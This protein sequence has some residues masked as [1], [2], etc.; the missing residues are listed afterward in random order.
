M[1]ENQLGN[2][3]TFSKRITAADGTEI[4]EVL[5]VADVYAEYASLS[6][7]YHVGKNFYLEAFSGAVYLPSFEKAPFPEIFVE[8]NAAE[9]IAAMLKI[10]EEFPFIGLKFYCKKGASGIWGEL[11]TARLQNKGRELT[12]PFSTP[13]LS[14]NEIKILGPTDHIGVQIINYGSGVLGPG[15]YI[16]INGDFRFHLDLVAKPAQAIGPA[17]PYGTS[18]GSSPIRF[19]TA[20]S[21]RAILYAVNTGNVPVWVA[22]N[23]SV[24]IGSG[25]FLAPNGNGSLTEHTLTGE[26]WAI[27]EGGNSLITGIEASYG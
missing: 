11:T 2:T 17:I 14:I 3:D 12:I 24:A 27:A 22:G 18:I 10:E 15:D 21:N 25:I 1:P 13:Y 8:M 26:F 6:S 19:R 7:T 5:R 23:N 9:K 4:I 16:N 20:N